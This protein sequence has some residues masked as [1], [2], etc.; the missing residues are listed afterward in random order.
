V[1]LEDDL[2]RIAAAASRHAGADA[3]AAVLPAEP[4]PGAR[5]YL[6]AFEAAAGG[7]SWL[8]L[9]DGGAPVTVRRTLRDAV[10]IAALCELAEDAAR[11]TD[12]DELLAQLVALRIAEAPDGIEEAEE[13]LLCLQRTVGVPPQLASPDRLDAIGAAVR[14]LELALDPAAGSSFTAAMRSAREV[15]EALAREVETGYRVPLAE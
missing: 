14:R 15:A 6:C 4:S 5:T 7:R 9:D 11:A 3:V 13:A 12:L 1:A 10:T 2:A 8:A